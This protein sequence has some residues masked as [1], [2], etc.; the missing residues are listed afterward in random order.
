MSRRLCA[1][2]FLMV[3][4]IGKWNRYFLIGI[5]FAVVV[6]A[7][8]SR[9]DNR[10][11]SKEYEKIIVAVTPWPASA[12]LYVARE[13]GYFRD[14]GIEAVFHPY[15]S[16]HLGLD[17]VVSGNADLATVGDTPF[18]RSVIGGMPVTIIATLCEINRAVLV[19]GRKDRGISSSDDLRG[20]TIGV[21]SGT[22]A[23][24]FLHIFLTISYIA[25]ADVRIISL[26][27]EEL[28]DALVAGEVDA[29]STWSPYTIMAKDRLGDNGVIFEEPGIY[30]MTWNIAAGKDFT[31]NH[32]ERVRR[33]LR[34]IVEAN[35]FIREQADEAR[36]ITSKY[37]GTGSRLF[38]REWENYAFTAALDQSL[39]V[40][41]EDQAR[42]MAGRYPDSAR[43]TPNFMDFIYIDGL[44]AVQPSAVR[45]TGK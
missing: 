32:P 37:V 23:D 21:V 13:K 11:A 45:I 15:V 5:A 33:V 27:T 43:K 12:A 8:C 36:A 42:W 41:L 26:R 4:L 10:S 38:D 17:A 6:T 14:E 28:V 18:A 25:P 44:K 31:E 35:R 3:H 7:A 22:T 1:G 9:E 40:N 39:I 34:A 29:V 2:F 19:I 20:R 30:K 16:G 24:F